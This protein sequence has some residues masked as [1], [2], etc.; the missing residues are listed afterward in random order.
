[1]ERW[2]YRR[3]FS[4]FVW[5]GSAEEVR[6]IGPALVTANRPAPF[7]D[8]VRDRALAQLHT[9]WRRPGPGRFVYPVIPTGEVA[10][11]VSAGAKRR[12]V[13]FGSDR[14]TLPE[15]WHLV[16]INGKH[17]YGKFVKVAL[18][19]LKDS[20]TDDRSVPNALTGE[21]EALF[22]GRLPPRPRVRLV[23]TPGSLVWEILTA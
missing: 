13:M 2:E 8:A 9:Y 23:K 20:A 15:G 14:E 5:D 11:E 17:L 19:V 22:G 3:S 7:A 10:G 18:N 16:L 12:S 21:I 6:Y 4:L 1:M